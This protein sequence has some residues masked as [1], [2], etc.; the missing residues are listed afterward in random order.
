MRDFDKVCSTNFVGD[1]KICA[2]E[3]KVRQLVYQ[4]AWKNEFDTKPFE[5]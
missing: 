4:V 5:A 1:D 2:V 3:D